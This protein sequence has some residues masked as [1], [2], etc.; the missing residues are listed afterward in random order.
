MSFLKSPYLKGL[1]AL[2]F[3]LFSVP[4][5]HAHNGG[6]GDGG[7]EP[8]GKQLLQVPADIAFGAPASDNLGNHNATMRLKMSGY[9]IELGTGCRYAQ[10]KTISNQELSLGYWN[11]CIGPPSYSAIMT[12]EYSG[13][14]TGN[15]GIGWNMTNPV[16]QL[17][18]SKNSAG[19]PGSSTWT[20]VSDRRLKKDI[21]S[22]SEGLSEL[23]K[24]NAVSYAYNGKAGIEETD[25]F[26]GVIA[27]DLQ[28]VAPH[29]VKEHL[30]ID[31]QDREEQYLA[32]DLHALQFME[33]NAIKELDQELQ[34]QKEINASL[35]QEL[36][37]LKALVGQ[38]VE[39]QT[40]DQDKAL[41]QLQE[42]ASLE[43][44]AP[45]PFDEVT[46]IR[47]TLP[48]ATRNAQLQVL[49]ING[50]VV[51]D[52]PLK[53]ADGQVSLDAAS[54][55]AGTYFYKLVVDGQTVASKRMVLTK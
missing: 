20:I 24:I 37:E 3:V 27:Q 5:L 32:V 19:K 10:I 49:D 2:L 52:L 33:L 43:Q 29:M 31:D 17:Q 41:Q 36:S 28:Q 8:H 48:E 50:Q 54:L 39:G 26:V 13:V 34:M 53:A 45:N 15:V 18:L 23:R 12:L 42:G 40:V 9:P 11:G 25:R 4:T 6:L 30:Y 21:Q 55:S 1:C 47:Y 35:Q 22:Y 38:L 14:R 51:R 46:V 7:T 44:N 16:Y